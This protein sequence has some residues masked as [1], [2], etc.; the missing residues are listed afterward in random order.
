MQHRRTYDFCDF[1][2]HPHGCVLVPKLITSVAFLP[3]VLLNHKKTRKNERFQMR[4]SDEGTW[5]KVHS[6][7]AVVPIVKAPLVYK[8]GQCCTN[9]AVILKCSYKNI[10]M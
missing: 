8:C 6:S 4:P 9:P 1:W 7:R 10:N 2:L 5:R 3:D